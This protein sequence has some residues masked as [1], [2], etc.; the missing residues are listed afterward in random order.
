M[1]FFKLTFIAVFVTSM[2]QAQV[3][4]VV[5]NKEDGGFTFTIQKDIEATT[6][7]NQYRS[8]TCW[9]FSTLSFFE[10]EVLRETKKK[11]DLAEMYIVWHTYMDKAIKYVRMHGNLNFGA[12]GAFHDVTYVWKKYG[13]LPENAFD[14]LNYGT[15]KHV[16]AEMDAALKAFVSS[17]IQNKN[18]TLTTAWKNAFEGILNSYLGEVPKEFE[19]DGK[20]YTPQSYSKSLGLNM[21]DYIPVTSFSHHPFYSKFAIEVPD[22]W[23]NEQYYNVPLNELVEIMDYALENNYSIAWA[24]DVSE[25][26]FSWVNGV[27]VVP[28]TDIEELSDSERQKWSSLSKK[29]QNKLAYDFSKPRQEKK[30]TQEMRQEAYD[31]FQTTDDHGMHITGVAK[32]QNGT[33]YYLVKNSWGDKSNEADG[34]FFASEAFIKYKTM[35]ILIHKNGIPKHI[36]KK[37]GIK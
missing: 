32:D 18:K 12:G 16:H 15:K 13:M 27:A 34:Y 1:K 3:N 30:I 26:G 7:K 9:S 11:V 21:D 5:K 29:E 14:G 24:S 22:N 33:K 10:S 6:V 19:V 2:L 28:E 37:L 31:N 17:I 35:D 8:G 20:K 23:M 25:K 36:R 4:N